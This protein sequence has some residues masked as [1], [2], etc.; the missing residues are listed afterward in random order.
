MFSLFNS[1]TSLLAL[2]SLYGC[3][4]FS[5]GNLFAKTAIVEQQ[6]SVTKLDMGGR[7]N[8]QRRA[9]RKRYQKNNDMLDFI[10]E[11]VLVFEVYEADEIDETPE[12]IYRASRCVLPDVLFC[13]PPL[14][15][16]PSFF[17]RLLFSARPSLFL[18]YIYLF[19]F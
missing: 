6:P 17:W 14:F 13:P 4:A 19:V 3:S 15:A 18:F 12:H 7:T 5:T 8:K 9:D 10:D 2:A 16:R 11:P 1:I